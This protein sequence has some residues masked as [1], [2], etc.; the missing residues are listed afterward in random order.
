MKMTQ[1]AVRMFAIFYRSCVLA[2]ILR[3]TKEKISR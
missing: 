2:F 1:L 3:E